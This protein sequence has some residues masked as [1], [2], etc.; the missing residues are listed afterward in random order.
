MKATRLPLLLVPLALAACSTTPGIG[1]SGAKTVATGA[2]GGATAVNANEQLEKCDKTLGTLSIVEE[3]NQPWIQQFTA[4]YRMQSTVPL[5]RMIVQQSNCF[6]IVE[7]GQAFRNMQTE[8]ELMQS[9]ELRKTSNIGKGQMVAADYTVTP[10]V[11]FSAKGTG[12]YGALLGGRIGLVASLVG[13]SMK[14]NEAST[15]LLLTDNR[16]GLQLAAAEGSAK[17]W[18]FGMMAGFFH[19]GLAGA[20]GFS[21]TPQ[22]KVLAASFM[23]SYNQL[24]K[25]VRSYKA[26]SVEGGLGNGGQLKTN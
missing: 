25:A 2:A 4:E 24:V 8:R 9:G 3:A 23:D 7:R 5:L 12:D 1:S 13:G 10:S 26:Q 14:S 17:N 21:N 18:D 20:S 15:M 22:G 11:T 19:H 6:A 16:S